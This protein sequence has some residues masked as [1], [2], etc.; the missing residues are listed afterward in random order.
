VSAFPEI[1]FE[2]FPATMTRSDADQGEARFDGM[3]DAACARRITIALL[4]RSSQQ[5]LSD[6]DLETSLLIRQQI[7]GFLE[8][9]KIMTTFAEMALTR[10]QAVIREQSRAYWPKRKQ[11]KR[12][13][14]A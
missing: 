5:L 11:Y 10:I 13:R 3:G 6:G 9:S 12:A 2:H 1:S 8:D 14:R 7:E 4:T